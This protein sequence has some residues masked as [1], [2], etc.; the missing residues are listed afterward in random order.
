MNLT[1]MKLAELARMFDSTPE[2]AIAIEIAGRVVAVVRGTYNEG[3]EVTVAGQCQHC[4]GPVELHETIR[5]KQ[6]I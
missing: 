6:I 4:G 2:T 1:Q 5:L 3:R